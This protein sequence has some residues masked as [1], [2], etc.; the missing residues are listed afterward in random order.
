MESEWQRRSAIPFHVYG[1]ASTAMQGKIHF[2]GGCHT[3][4][5][6]KPSTKHQ[7]YD[8]ATDTWSGAADLPLDF[9][10]AMPAVLDGK[11][12]LFGGGFHKPGVGLC[13]TDA[14]WMYDRETDRWSRLPAMPDKRM[15]G[16]AVAVGDAI[17]ICLGYDRQGGRD[18]D[19]LQEYVSTYRYDPAEGR[20][21]RVA[22]APETGCYI[23]AGAHD[24]KVYAVSGTHHEATDMEDRGLADDALVY[25]PI[26]DGWERIPAP[27]IEK[28][29]FYLTQCSASAVRDARLYVIGGR[30]PAGRTRVT[31]YFDI[32]A[33]RFVR[34]PD[35][36]E[37]RCCGGGAIASGALIIA[38][39]FLGDVGRPAERVWRLSLDGA[40]P[41]VRDR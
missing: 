31:S 41:S 27:R 9:G 1:H 25:D 32:E 7:V 3:E 10:W 14:A 37:G 29:V 22:D 6:Q 33:R 40:A 30:G 4:D 23:A 35:L 21:A 38:G 34:A 20:Y 5:W 13:A 24:G 18:S 2:L 11:L 36:P 26:S 39:G 16:C 15:N 19:V 12:Y 28:R 8:P 17:Y